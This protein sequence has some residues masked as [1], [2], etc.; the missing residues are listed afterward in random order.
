MNTALCSGVCI[1]YVSALTSMH[2][3]CLSTCCGLPFCCT[4]ASLHLC[5]SVCPSFN[6]DQSQFCSMV[7]NDIVGRVTLRRRSTRWIRA[8]LQFLPA[9]KSWLPA[10][11]TCQWC[12]LIMTL[13]WS[14]LPFNSKA[15][16]KANGQEPAYQA[17]MW[18]VCIIATVNADVWGCLPR[19]ETS[20]NTGD[21]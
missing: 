11:Q 16:R 10:N 1:T 9:T 17:G 21:Q 13:P 4:P 7:A 12:P 14:S 3:T 2:F 20:T 19:E 18:S 6:N 15:S 8:P 5:V